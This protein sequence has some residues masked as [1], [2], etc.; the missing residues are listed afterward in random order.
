MGDIK[1]ELHPLDAL[2]KEYNMTRYA[3]SKHGIPE[4]TSSHIVNKNIPVDNITVATLVKLA[5]AL[6][7]DL[8][9]T[10]ARLKGYERK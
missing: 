1:K 4:S 6:G 2:L 9:E 8:E 7:L 10:Y 3:L 5:N